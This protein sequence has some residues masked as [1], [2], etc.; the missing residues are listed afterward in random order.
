MVSSLICDNQTLLGG[1]E[2]GKR[3]PPECLGGRTVEML[4]SR[5]RRKHSMKNSVMIVEKMVITY[6]PARRLLSVAKINVLRE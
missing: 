1:Q 6:Q 2:F 3:R 4:E 5:L